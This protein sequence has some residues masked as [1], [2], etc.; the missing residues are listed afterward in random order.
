MSNV[1]RYIIH[2]AL[3]RHHNA[4][5]KSLKKSIPRTDREAIN[6]VLQTEFNKMMKKHHTKL[7]QRCK[8]LM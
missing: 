7:A 2:S 8:K 5:L 3:A 6:K 4:Q 1:R